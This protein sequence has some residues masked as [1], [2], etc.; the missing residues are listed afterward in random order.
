[1]IK[2]EG[3]GEGKSK[4]MEVGGGSHSHVVDGKG[5]IVDRFHFGGIWFQLCQCL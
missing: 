4:V 5:E 1:M 2:G 3:A